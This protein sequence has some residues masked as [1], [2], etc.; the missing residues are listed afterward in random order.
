MWQLYTHDLSE[1][2]GMIPGSEGL[3]K[4]GCLPS[5]L[6]APDKGGYLIVKGADLAQKRRVTGEKCDVRFPESRRDQ[7][8][9]GS[10]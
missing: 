3:F 8:T 10:S 7:R 4:A 5:Y 6:D 1:F 9:P 2:R